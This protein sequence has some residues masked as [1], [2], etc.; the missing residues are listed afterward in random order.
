MTPTETRIED[1]ARLA[2]EAHFADEP[3]PGVFP[4]SGL[5]AQGKAAWIRATR[6]LYAASLKDAAGVARERSGLGFSML[7]YPA[8]LSAETQ[9][10]I[11]ATALEAK[12]REASNA[13]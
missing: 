13:G 2:Y 9:A 5:P 12:A 3:Q 10:D 4:W 7:D 11:I 1:L 8:K 6:A